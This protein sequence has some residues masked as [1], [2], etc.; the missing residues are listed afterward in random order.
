MWG[1]WGMWRHPVVFF[2]WKRWASWGTL[3]PSVDCFWGKW[4]GVRGLFVRKPAFFL[5][6]RIL[7]GRPAP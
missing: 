4:L 2:C 1:F 5:L 3:R 6:K 7:S